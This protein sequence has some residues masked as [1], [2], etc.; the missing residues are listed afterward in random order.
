M[1]ADLHI[2]NIAVIERADIS[3]G[4][5]FNVLTGETGAGKSIVVDALSAV[6]GGRTSRELVRAGAP[7]ALVNAVFTGTDAGDWLRANDLEPGDELI[8]QRRIG[9]DGKSACRVSGAAVTVQQL[10]AL[11]AMLLDIHGQNDGREL[12][13]ESR[14]LAWLDRFAAA[15]EAS[16]AYGE[17]YERFRAIRAEID[18]LTMGELEK[19]RVT[20]TLTAE[21]AELEKADVRPGEEETLTA[22]A[23]LMKNSEKLTAALEGAYGALYEAD[24]NAIDLVRRAGEFTAAAAAYAPELGDAAKSV[25]DARFLLE[26]AAER[27][28]DLRSD[29]DFSEEEFDRIETRLALLRRLERKYGADEAGLVEALA[30]RRRQLA[31]IESADDL[32]AQLKKDLEKA[33]ERVLAAGRTLTE[34]R[35]AAGERLAKRVAAELKYLNMPSVKFLVEL[36]PVQ[37]ADGFHAAGCDEARFLMSANAGEAPGRIAHIASGGELSRIM[38]AMKC[39]FAAND[40]VESMVFDEIDAGISGIAAQRV[41][42]K[43]GELSRS[44]Q[45]L[46]ITHLPQIAAMADVHF[47]IAKSERG[48]RT[49]T[50]VAALDRA[51]R[52]KEL[53]R[54]L[55]GDAV[56]ETTLR[57]A[58]EQLDAADRFKR[59]L[60]ERGTPSREN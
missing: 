42:E 43:I 52:E 41:G 2:E 57:D 10:R 47:A 11:G 40:R 32:I 22:R 51:G 27:I 48:G 56:T 6:L 7:S 29:L 35:R 5:G 1:L 45:I 39:V 13:D 33:R 50:T 49:Y 46:C 20:D 17:A 34:T 18:R 26:D 9:A 38:L 24:E 23:N 36:T 37:N 59:G 60:N 16:A 31:E 12:L 21:I 8:V 19:A 58:A 15:P 55:G 25:A 3:F 30:A 44:R 14:H 53:A 28:G 54:L 4:P